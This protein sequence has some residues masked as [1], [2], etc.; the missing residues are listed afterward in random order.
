MA[1]E[2]SDL[3]R[4]R[5]IVIA[6]C[7]ALVLLDGIDTFIYGAVLPEMIG[8]GHLG[9]TDAT[10][11][12]IGSYTTFGMLVGTILSGTVTRWVGR[13][14]A[15]FASVGLFTVATLGCGVSTGA[16]MFGFFR[17][18]CGFGLG[19]LLPIAIAYGM[20]FSTGRRK[21]L[22]TGIIMTAHQTG[23]AIAPLIAL[24]LIDSAGWRSVFIASAVPAVVLLPIAIRLLPESPAI[25]AARGRHEES[26]AAAAGYGLDP[27]ARPPERP[28]RW[29]SM[30][31]LF[32][33][34][35]WSTTLLFWLTSFAGLM[36]VYGVGQW[37]PKI[38]G[39][40]GYETGDSLLFSTVLNLGGIV[41]MLVAGRL[42]DAVGPRRIVVLW[43]T[44]TAA[45]VYML[46]TH[47]PVAVL[48]VVVF[49]AGLLL[50]SGQTMVYATV[51]THH[52]SSDRDTALGWVAGMG[53]FGA[54]FG[55]WLG[56]ALLAAGHADYGFAAFA[57]TGLFGAVMMALATLTI[58]LRR[59]AV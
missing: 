37:L 27:I 36:L 38:M 47:L 41:G 35:Q 26:E 40:L 20:E 49:F 44:L 16:G 10:A 13:R 25:L 22:A 34:R 59:S 52:A 39:D 31:A 51:G 24:G 28:D 17:L 58:W 42:A 4:R 23:G 8:G 9:L 5:L 54:V 18:L 48:Y 2:S 56:G 11:G 7:W 30:K 15:V 32:R 33:D 45:F 43:F 55:P 12:N 29:E 1:S 19:A 21:A 14:P 3:A 53:R 6:V 46:G 57:A 50:F